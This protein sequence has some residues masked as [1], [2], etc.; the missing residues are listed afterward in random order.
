MLRSNDSQ[1]VHYTGSAVTLD[2]EIE[3]QS[4]TYKHVIAKIL[5][6][7]HTFLNIALKPL[8]IGLDYNLHP[9]QI[10]VIQLQIAQNQTIHQHSAMDQ[11]INKST[12]NE[13]TH[14]NTG[15]SHKQQTD[16]SWAFRQIMLHILQLHWHNS[17]NAEMP[18]S[19]METAYLL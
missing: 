14:Q 17:I 12:K 16:W 19:P 2:V 15:Q 11:Q 7:Y 5:I 9:S 4:G 3:W 8:V 6:E 18:T 10:Y 1:A 13:P